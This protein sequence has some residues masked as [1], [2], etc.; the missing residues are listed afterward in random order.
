MGCHEGCPGVVYGVDL[1][2]D[3]FE[4]LL[5]LVR[6]HRQCQGLGAIER[7]GPVFHQGAPSGQ[8]FG[9][10]INGFIPGWRDIRLHGTTE[11]G[12]HGG[13]DRVGFGACSGCLGEASHLQWVDFDAWQCGLAER[14]FQ[15]S[16]IGAGCLED[17]AFWLQWGDPGDEPGNTLAI[18]VELF[19]DRVGM[20][21]SIQSVFRDV[22]SKG[23]L[24]RRWCYVSL[25]SQPVRF[26]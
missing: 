4:M 26:L 7:C 20:Q 10:T 3:L 16:V 15:C 24:I 23:D 25:A 8:Q 11:S 13:V 5:A 2:F 9:K 14:H 1:G 17:D 19:D 6:Q 22:D 18:I 12:E 21:M